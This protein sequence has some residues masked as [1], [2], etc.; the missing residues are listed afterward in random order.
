MESVKFVTIGTMIFRIDLIQRIELKVKT[1]EVRSSE[2][3][4]VIFD[5][6]EAAKKAFDRLVEIL[7]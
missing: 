2:P 6:E 7:P 5:N 4:T 1:I 3:S